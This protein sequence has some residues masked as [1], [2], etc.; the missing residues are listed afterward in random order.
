MCFSVVSLLHR[1]SEFQCFGW[2]ETNQNKRAELIILLPNLPLEL[3]VLKRPALPLDVPV[4][5]QPVLPLNVSV[6]Q[7][8]FLSPVV[9]ILQQPVVPVDA[10]VLQQHVLPLCYIWACLSLYKCFCAAL[11][12]V[13][14]QEPVLHLS[15]S[16]YESFS[17]TWTCLPAKALSAPGVVWSS[18]DFFGLVLN[19][20]LHFWCGCFDTGNKRN[21][22]RVT[23]Q[24]NNRNRLM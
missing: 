11:G 3:S 9:S 7:Q 18:T 23:Y 20:K 24:K 15:V 6:L 17:C 22:F 19:K 1:N 5:Q 4:L 14:L 21:F 13:C 2:T 8:P 10:S 12:C 16:V